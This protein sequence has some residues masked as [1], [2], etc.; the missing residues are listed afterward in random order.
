MAKAISPMQDIHSI[1]KNPNR[2]LNVIFI[3]LAFSCIIPFIFI[4]MISISSE[5]SIKEFGYQFIPQAFSL[6]GYKYVIS[7]SDQLMTSYMVTISV[8]VLGTLGGLFLIS[9]YAY[10]L[11]RRDF[12]YKRFFTVIAV[13]PML[14]G[15][16]MV[17]NYMIVSRFLD[18]KDTIF[19][20]ILPMMMNSTYMFVLKSFI[21]SSVPDAIV[22][23]A[24]IDGASE[25]RIF[26]RVVM[27]MVI[28]GLA[29][30][31]L[32]LVLGYWND[33]MNAML[34]IE[35][36]KLMPLQYLLIRIENSMSF[37]ADNAAQMGVTGIEAAANLPK[38]SAKMAIVVL[39]TV[40]IL[41]AYPFFQKYFVKGL[42][43]GAVKE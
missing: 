23:S 38:D 35:T 33:W 7:G 13:I 6:E 42:N 40:P 19:A 31:A 2:I 43:L 4:L 37:L 3:A 20:L 39:S 32:F 5:D 18:I 27:P 12:A 26:F 21:T 11:S 29:T 16:G 34:Y 22:E 36:D 17:A 9:T 30:I 10:A 14:F 8:T 1:G 24:R 25:W 28:P 15:G 41:F